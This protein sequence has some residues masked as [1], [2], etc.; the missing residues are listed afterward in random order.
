M[1]FLGDLLGGGLGAYGYG[2]LM[3]QIGDDR[4]NTAQKIGDMQQGV[5]ERTQFQPWSIKGGGI[6]QAGMGQDGNMNL[7]L[8]PHQQAIRKQMF[9][10]GKDL[11]GQAAAGSMDPQAREQ[12]IFG[13]MQDAYLPEQQRQ[14]QR[15]Q[16]QM[17]SQGRG[18]MRTDM[19]G[20]T[21]EQ[22]AMYKAQAEQQQQA[23]VASMG[24]AQQEIGNQYNQG[25]GFMN[26]GYQPI[27]Q[28]MQKAQLGLQGNQQ[29]QNAQQ[30]NANMWTQLGL[31]GITADTNYGN[32]EGNAFG[33]MINAAM[34]LAQSAG[35]SA[36]GWLSSLFSSG[37]GGGGD[38]GGWDGSGGGY[39]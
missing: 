18:G 25:M 38:W 3:N 26:Q 30:N 20:G 28:L 37:G 23:Q 33:N 16:Q 4:Q 35:D 2:S 22:L 19:Y 32:M 6:G 24:L 34:P 17:L 21:P 14:Q 13:R 36:S 9:G 7:S 11:L 29:F 31:G 39:F 27:N 1:A 12:E 10:S 15:M 8:T 5:D